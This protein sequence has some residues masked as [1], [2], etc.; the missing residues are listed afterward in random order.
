M[1]SETRGPCSRCGLVWLASQI[2]EYESFLAT[3]DRVTIYKTRVFT[4][5]SGI[6]HVLTKSLALGGWQAKTDFSKA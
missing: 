4:I 5:F 3:L 6:L 2:N 1:A